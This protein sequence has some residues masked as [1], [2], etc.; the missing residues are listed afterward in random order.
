MLLQH[1]LSKTLILKVTLLGEGGG[2]MGNR[3]GWVRSGPGL[4]RTTASWF[5]IGQ[6]HVSRLSLQ[7]SDWA[8][9]DFSSYLA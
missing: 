5:L 8:N 2:I 4:G 9:P 7:L 1:I 3:Q 6:S